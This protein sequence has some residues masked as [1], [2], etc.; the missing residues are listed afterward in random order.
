LANPGVGPGVYFRAVPERPE[1]SGRAVLDSLLPGAEQFLEEG[2][3]PSVSPAFVESATRVF[4][5]ATQA[6]RE[7]LLGCVLARLLDREID[8]RKPYSRQGA[9]SF[10]GRSLDEIVV[11]PFLQDN[12]IPATRGPYLSVFRRQVKF[13]P[14]DRKGL[15]DK[16][17]F[18]TLL[19]CLSVV[20][21]TKGDSELKEII[22]YLLVLFL[23]LR[24]Q[25]QIALL[26]VQRLSVDQ[27]CALIERLLGEPSGGRF[28]LLV[29]V[30]IFSGLKKVSGLSYEVS[31]QGINVAD[32]ATGA[33]GDITLSLGARPLLGV[34][35]TERTVDRG[36]VRDTFESK[37]APAG[38][39]DYLFLVTTPPSADSFEFTRKLFAQ[40]SAVNIL[41]IRE[42]AKNI[43]A[44]AGSE[45]C[46][47]FA[48]Q[49]RTLLE[50]RELP[51]RLKLFW[52]RC[53]ADLVGE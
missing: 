2:S 22:T 1:I 21:G 16:A 10:N 15:R 46:S 44:T 53:I 31:W 33:A 50:G 39:Q 40:G 26:R 11:N 51:V 7:V 3:R 30:A 43:L 20:E 37:I 38:L 52:N 47:A 48:D 28:A 41:D 45:A 9:G 42:W 24:Q 5:S 36:R 19:N 18:D 13:H 17:G 8:I 35:V 27:C 32:S 12:L 49:L 4:S 23:E 34:E 6:Y 29:A 14:D 25:S